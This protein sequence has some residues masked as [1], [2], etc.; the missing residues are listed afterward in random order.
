[1]KKIF[2]FFL[3]TFLCLPLSHTHAAEIQK[4]VVLLI[5]ASGSMKGKKIE[6]VRSAVA[7]IFQTIRKDQPIEIITFNDHV[8]TLIR[9]T[10]NYDL[11]IARLSSIE[12]SGKTSLFDAIHVGLSSL[13]NNK[14][15]QIIVLSDGNDTSSKIGLKS[16]INQII[17]SE[18]PINTIG[19]QIQ[20]TEKAILQKISDTSKGKYYEVNDISKLTATY[21]VILK[22]KLEAP[23]VSN[24]PINKLQKGYSKP[25]IELLLAVGSGLLVF[26]LLLFFN[27]LRQNS[28]FRQA[29]YKTLEKYAS[30]RLKRVSTKVKIPFKSYRFIPNRVENKIRTKL[31]LIHSDMTY[32]TCVRALVILWVFLVIFFF[33]PFRSVVIAAIFASAL[34]PFLF[35][36]VT[37]NIRS[38]Q[39]LKFGEDLP[40]LLNI[41]AGALRAGLSLEQGLEAYTTDT[42]GEVSR[43]VRRALGEIKVGT[44]IDEA[45]MSV[46]N[47]MNNEDLKWAVTALSI[48]R[49]V[50][51]SMATILTT[52]FETVKSRAEIRRE[53]K[54]LSAEGKLSAYV[55][56]SLP[57]GIFLF[58]L[59]TRRQYVRIF[60]SDPAGMFLLVIIGVALSLGWAWMKRIVEIKI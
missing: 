6:T 25:F 20:P 48:Q 38:R 46:S 24:P 47:R 54:T 33:L 9:P 49:V 29:R 30:P 55:L 28:S 12:V 21:Q 14:I 36:L 16:I 3:I 56:M 57:I 32:E 45:L 39:E 58:L 5:D 37:N 41:L 51:G 7:Q 52:A 35:N 42:D 18:T 4:P 8:R 11:A 26:L 50:G 44:P 2:V 15:D 1:M 53:V 27:R 34:V 43:E 31:E 22:Q 10:T 40:E 23:I 17:T 13:G 59:L 60:W 19:V